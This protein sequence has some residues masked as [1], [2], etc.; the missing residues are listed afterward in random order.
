MK[1]QFTG[2]LD[3]K[4]R[5]SIQLGVA[6]RYLLGVECLVLLLI[7][8]SIF[9]KDELF[10]S[11]L[12]AVVSILGVEVMRYWFNYSFNRLVLNR[13]CKE[14]V[15]RHSKELK[16]IINFMEKYDSEEDISE[17]SL[18]KIFKGFYKIG[19][20][21]E[22]DS[23]LELQSK[24]RMDLI[25]RIRADFWI[26]QFRR[27]RDIVGFIAYLLCRYNHWYPRFGFTYPKDNKGTRKLAGILTR[28]KVKE[29]QKR[30]GRRYGKKIA[31]YL[32]GVRQQ[33]NL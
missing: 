4:Q 28:K 23:M 2:I 12:A 30:Y 13:F 33:E 9:S 10:V 24:M 3:D 19:R 1:F 31:N 29:C 8:L 27:R 32:Y 11:V 16:L 22:E 26:L 20:H 5:R 6:C 17:E 14:L 7:I 18:I 15:T 25:T 21:M